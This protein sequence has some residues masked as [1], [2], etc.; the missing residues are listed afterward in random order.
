M[1]MVNSH[2]I[3]LVCIHVE[4]SVKHRWSLATALEVASTSNLLEKL[5]YMYIYMQGPPYMYGP[6]KNDKQVVCRA[7]STVFL[8]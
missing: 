3:T 7:T 5:K 6:A 4:A 8:S 1:V 2:C